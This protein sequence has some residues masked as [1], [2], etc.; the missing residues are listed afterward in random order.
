MTLRPSTRL[1]LLLLTLPVLTGCPAHSRVERT[2]DWPRFLG[3]EGRAI[4]TGQ[5]IPDRFGP[6]VNL[7]WKIE[8]PV[9]QSSPVTWKERLYLTG[10]REGQLVVSCHR[11]SDGERLWEKTFEP[12]GT[13]DFQHRDSSPAIPTAALDA[14]RVVVYFGARGLIALDHA[15]ELLWEKPFPLGR[16]PFGFGASPLLR[17]GKI[18]LQRDVAGLS[19]LICFDAEDGEIIWETPRPDVRVNYGSPCFWE[20][21]GRL[22]IVAG[23][24]GTLRGYDAESGE[25]LWSLGDFPAFVCTTP[26]AVGDR[27]VYGAWNT[28]NIPGKDRIYTGID[29]DADIPQEVLQDMSR[30]IEHF[31]R[32]GDQKV[33][34]EELPESR[35]RDV[36]VFFDRNRDGGWDL[37]ELEPLDDG[38]AA[39][40]RNV[41]VAIDGRGPG[42]ITPDDIV[43]EQTRGLPYVATPLVHDD[44]VFY[45]KKGG[46]VTCVDLATGEAHYERSRLGLGGEYYAT[47]VLAGGRILVAAERGAVFVLGAG[48]EFE[49]IARNE[50]GEGLYATPA[51]VDDTIYLRSSGHLWAFTETG[52]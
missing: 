26:V 31:D 5:T 51:V 2:A 3:P 23:G 52:S 46:F 22:E 9:G 35:L 10:Y 29:E 39:P 4:A 38:P 33:Q 12:A 47:P 8:V 42:P 27:L 13:E 21:D 17:E 11:R 32:N 40:G 36:F 48:K 30:F 20:R 7:A 15:G 43:W 6:D 16:S 18:F 1:L 50:I 49:V 34:A 44:R 45:V 25:E 41:V 28:S 19:S 24:S 14:K 37:A